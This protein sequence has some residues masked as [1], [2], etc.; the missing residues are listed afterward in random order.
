MVMKDFTIDI[1][2]KLLSSLLE[3]D[4][5]FLT[6]LDFHL[7]TSESNKRFIT[8]RH[9]V[10]DLK[11]NSLEFAKIQHDLGIK[12][13]YYFRVIPQSFDERIIKEVYEMGHEIGYHYETMDTCRG[14]VDMAYK[15]FC[16]HLDMFRK[17]SPI[18]TICMHGSPLSKFDN[19]D[20]WKKYDYQKLGIIAEPYFDVD[21]SKTY[22]LTDTGRRW[23][24]NKVSVRD[25]AIND[26]KV[27]NIDF[28]KRNYYSTNE[29]ITDLKK[30]DFPEKVMM[31]FHPQ[32]WSNNNYFWLKELLLQNFKN[33]IKRIIVK[34]SI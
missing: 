23:N 24:G 6:Y 5:Q 20:I 11:E 3:L 31:T 13:T 17:I 10:D 1:Y 25:K 21:F 30:R 34:K 14:N 33:Q 29:I 19:R 9:D 18:K 7:Q 4:F 16:V 32:R 26:D 15:E 22:Y 8:L 2:K 12:S 27:S 28:N